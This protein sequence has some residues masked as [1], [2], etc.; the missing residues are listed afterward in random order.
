MSKMDT[1][2]TLEHLLQKLPHHDMPVSNHLSYTYHTDIF[3]FALKNA[4]ITNL[5]PLFRFELEHTSVFPFY[6]SF[7]HS[8]SALA[9]K[10]TIQISHS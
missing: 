7:T 9:K 6:S 5:S 8:L 4:L 1:M 2:N 10:I 3:N